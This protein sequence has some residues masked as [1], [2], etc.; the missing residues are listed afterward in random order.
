MGPVAGGTASY[1]NQRLAKLTRVTTSPESSPGLLNPDKIS[2]NQRP[3]TT[4]AQHSTSVKA[5]LW[6]AQLG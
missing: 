6:D 4:S 1:E 5:E 2:P 3:V